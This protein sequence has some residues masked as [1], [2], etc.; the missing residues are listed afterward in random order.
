MQAQERYIMNTLTLDESPENLRYTMFEI[1]L[2]DI[3]N[4]YKAVNPALPLCIRSIASKT[5]TSSEAYL[6]ASGYFFC[7]LKLFEFFAHLSD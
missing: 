5:Y 4:F 2:Q 6:G 1:M 3:C 7:Y